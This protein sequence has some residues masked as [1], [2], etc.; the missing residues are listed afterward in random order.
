MIEADL[1]MS[2]RSKY[3]ERIKTGDKV[4]EFRRTRMNA[5]AGTLVLVYESLPTGLVTMRFRVGEAS[6]YAITV[7][8]ALALEKPGPARDDLATYLTGA[9]CVTAMQITEL[10]V[11]DPPVTL[12]AATGLDRAPMSYQRVG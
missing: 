11:L 10:E 9:R 8:E 6:Q 5:P 4:F 7:D 3:A 12:K 1:V 2:L